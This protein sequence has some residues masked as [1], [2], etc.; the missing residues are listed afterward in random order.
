LINYV[1]EKGENFYIILEGTVSVL[2]PKEVRIEITEEE[3]L[4]YLAKCKKYEEFDIVQNCMSN[5][6]SVFNIEDDWMNWIKSTEKNLSAEII[7][8]LNRKGEFF[9]ELNTLSS[10]ENNNKLSISSEEY[11]KRIALVKLYESRGQEKLVT[12]YQYQKIVK[13]FT[14]GKFGELRSEKNNMKR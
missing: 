10:N 7:I 12:I 8:K 9:R 2:K 13:K 14:G 1:G 6:K 11:I 4:L 3:Y 5:N